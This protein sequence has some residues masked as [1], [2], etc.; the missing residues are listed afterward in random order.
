[1]EFVAIYG[2]SREA[3]TPKIQILSL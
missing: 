3:Q 2:A 1:M